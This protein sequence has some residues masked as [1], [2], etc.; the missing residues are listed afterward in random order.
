MNWRNLI[1]LIKEPLVIMLNYRM[2]N[3][4]FF[5]FFLTANSIAV[6]NL[7]YALWSLQKKTSTLHRIR[8]YLSANTIWCCGNEFPMAHELSFS[9]HIVSF[10]RDNRRSL[11]IL[12]PHSYTSSRMKK[13][14]LEI[15]MTLSANSIFNL[16]SQ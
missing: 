14:F 2:R 6:I 8:K 4:L 11:A 13:Y 10:Y 9:V 12:K 3:S 7:K 16:K 5:F 15:G 1:P